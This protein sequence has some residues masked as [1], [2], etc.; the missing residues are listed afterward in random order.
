[1]A[2]RGRSRPARHTDRVTSVAFSPDGKLIASG[3]FD[4][5]LRVWDAETGAPLAHKAELSSIRG[6][7]FHPH[8]DRIALACAGQDDPSLGQDE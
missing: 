1:M 4:R 2:Y 3:S 7:A 8:G 5:S 6:V